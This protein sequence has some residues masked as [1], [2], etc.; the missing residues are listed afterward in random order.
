M[1]RGNNEVWLEWA[2]TVE[3][4]EKA[5]E[6]G[7][8]PFY[9]YTLPLAIKKDPKSPV[10]ENKNHVTYKSAKPEYIAGGIRCFDRFDCYYFNSV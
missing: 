2:P 8:P 6:E 9:M 3:A 5:E 7:K 4:K 1:Y 10:F